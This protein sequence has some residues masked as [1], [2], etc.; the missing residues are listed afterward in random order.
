MKFDYNQWC[1]QK[2]N[3]DIIHKFSGSV[4]SEKITETLN[5]VENNLMKSDIKLYKRKKVFNVLLECVQ[6][7]YHHAD[8]PPLSADVEIVPRFGTLVLSKDRTFYRI[9][10]G[11]FLRKERM[12]EVEE[13][14]KMVNSLSDEDIVLIY[15][16]V[17]NNQ[18]ASPNSAGLGLL[19]MVRKTGNKLEYYIY[20]QDDKYS[21]LSMDVYIS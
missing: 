14:L 16:D 8:T 13:R 12:K 10:T 3:G 17:L 2:L 15:R 6:N 1:F 19:D 21:F 11:N 20:T 5:S 18:Q 7:L 4:T 9:S